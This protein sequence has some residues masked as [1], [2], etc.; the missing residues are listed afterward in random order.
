[1][2]YGKNEL[3]ISVREAIIIIA[4]RTF[5]CFCNHSIIIELR[6]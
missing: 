4:V 1:M 6:A 2:K 5:L 3:K